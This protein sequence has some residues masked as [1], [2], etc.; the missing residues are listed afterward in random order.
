VRG[1]KE[2]V[3]D[4]EAGVVVGSAENVIEAEFETPLLLAVEN[5]GSAECGGDEVIG[6]GGACAM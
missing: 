2:C 4:L 1:S 3:S 6:V 5:R